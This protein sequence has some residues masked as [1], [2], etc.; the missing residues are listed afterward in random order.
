VKRE[1]PLVYV[2][3][4]VRP[5]T[6][7]SG[8]CSWNNSWTT[9]CV[10]CGLDWLI[11]PSCPRAVVSLIWYRCADD[12]G[13]ACSYVRGLLRS[14]TGAPLDASALADYLQL[15]L[16]PAEVLGELMLGGRWLP[17]VQFATQQVPGAVH[18]DA[19][20]LPHSMVMHPR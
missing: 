16:P 8:L 6:P 7:Q 10:A 20:L 18:S 12:G 14:R 19:L 11:N 1:W 17:A 5:G 3:S 4:R 13:W 15:P 9:C 2:P